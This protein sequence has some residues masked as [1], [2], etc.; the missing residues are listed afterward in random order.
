MAV[1]PVHKQLSDATVRAV[2][3]DG[4]ARSH[5][6]VLDILGGYRAGRKLATLSVTGSRVEDSQVAPRR[7]HLRR[8]APG[9]AARKNCTMIT[10]TTLGG[11]LAPSS[12]KVTS[13]SVMQCSISLAMRSLDDDLGAETPSKREE[14]RWSRRASLFATSLR[15]TM[16]STLPE[17]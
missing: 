5:P 3:D 2:S 13:I 8:P 17:M 10:S 12:I 11:R 15:G 7:H 1:A 9:A 6:G 16:L 4:V 14:K